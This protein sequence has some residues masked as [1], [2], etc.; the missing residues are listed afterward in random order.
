MKVAFVTGGSKGIGLEKV[1]R[2]VIILLTMHHL[3][4]RILVSSLKHSAP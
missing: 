2:L 1:L 4:H 3:K